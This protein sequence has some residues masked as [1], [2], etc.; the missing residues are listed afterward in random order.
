MLGLLDVLQAFV[1]RQRFRQRC[2]PR[3][4]D[5]VA[6]ETARIAM[7]TQIEGSRDSV[8]PKMRM[9]ASEGEREEKE[10][11]RWKGGERWFEC[12]AYLMYV[13]LLL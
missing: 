6:L 1:V 7:K 9:C 10:E 12:L 8:R 2:C 5:V 4:T 3:V 13:T 11:W